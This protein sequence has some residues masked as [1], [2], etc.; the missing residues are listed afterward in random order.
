MVLASLERTVYGP[1]PPVIVMMFSVLPNAENV[2][3]RALSVVVATAGVL[4]EE[5]PPQPASV[6]VKASPTPQTTQDKRPEK[7]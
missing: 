1:V 2:A 3:G 6:S 4:L 5:E 7:F